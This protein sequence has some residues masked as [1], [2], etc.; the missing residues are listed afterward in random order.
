V[1]KICICRKIILISSYGGESESEEEN[2]PKEDAQVST[3]QYFICFVL[4]HLL[5]VFHHFL[6][7][8]LK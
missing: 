7:N 8:F 2:L 4:C 1:S 5:I 3:K 6:F